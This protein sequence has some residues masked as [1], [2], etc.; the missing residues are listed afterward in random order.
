MSVP[1]RAA[2]RDRDRPWRALLGLAA[3]ALLATCATN[4]V[5]GESELSLVSEKDEIALGRQNAASTVQ[6]IGLI[7]DSSVQR[8]VSTL[9]KT[10][11]AHTERPSLPWSYQAVDDPAVN[12]F[13]LPGGFVFVT[14]G[15]L[16]H[17]NNEAELATVL[18][19]ESGHVAA[20]HSVHQ[21]SEAEVAQLGLGV[22]MAV[23]KQVAQYGQYAQQGLQ[24]LFLKFSR[25]DE[26]QA[27]ALG[28][29]YA[30]ADGYDVRQMI[31]VFQMLDGV[32]KEAGGQKLPEWE[33]T[34]PDP[35]NRV[36]A[37]EARLAKV[38][39]VD[40]SQYKVG[41]DQYLKMIDGMVY[42]QNPR[43]GYFE[44]TLFLYPDGKLQIQFPSGWQTQN[45]ADAVMAGS[46]Q[47]DAIIELR[48]VAGTPADAAQKFASTQGVTIGRSASGQVHGLSAL[49][50]EFSVQQEGQS[51]VQG[52]A[53]F[54]DYGGTTYRILSYAAA[55]TAGNY[56]SAFEQTITSFGP[57]TDPKALAIQPKRVRLVRVPTAMTITEFNAQYPSSIPVEELALINGLPSTAA[58][59]AGTTIKRIE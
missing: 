4:P 5:T 15:L 33:S 27:D 54:I 11:A 7:P 40:W 45:T 28:F 39:Q 24:V 25:D 51:P 34:H 10:L 19:H 3:I 48:A 32:T 56:V 42:G 29:R 23:S 22:G 38:G 50:R 31:P 43:N 49:E 58:I 12:A 52:I 55:A 44:N 16:T 36:T 13:A 8:Y 59:P 18:G 14:R 26:T 41:R 1:H 47:Q 21:M 17:I 20:K 6:A 30:M 9:G 35:G 46:P 53:A 37:T 57:L 2:G